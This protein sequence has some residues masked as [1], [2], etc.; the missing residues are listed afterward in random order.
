MIK[1]TIISV[2]VASQLIIANYYETEKDKTNRLVSHLICKLNECRQESDEVECA[3]AHALD[4]LEKY[5]RYLR[6]YDCLL[7]STK[8]EQKCMKEMVK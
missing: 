3:W 2:L 1:T 8:T 4:N 5:K 6:Y 7:Y